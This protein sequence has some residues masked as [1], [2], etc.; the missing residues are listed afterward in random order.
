MIGPSDSQHKIEAIKHLFFSTALHNVD[1]LQVHIRNIVDVERTDHTAKSEIHICSPFSSLKTL[2]ALS[3]N[4]H[5][6]LQ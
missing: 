6:I 2:C 1:I 3:M 5:S 4:K